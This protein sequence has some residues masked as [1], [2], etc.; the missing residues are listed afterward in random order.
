MRSRGLTESSATAHWQ[1]S[2]LLEVITSVVETI[3]R[4]LSFGTQKATPAVATCIERWVVWSGGDAARQ[5]NP[6]RTY[7]WYLAAGRKNISVSTGGLSS[8]NLAVVI[9]K[10]A[11]RA[12]GGPELVGSISSVLTALFG[13]RIAATSYRQATSLIVAFLF[14]HAVATMSAEAAEE[15]IFWILCG[16]LDEGSLYC[17]ILDT[18]KLAAETAMIWQLLGRT[19]PRFQA[20]LTLLFGG[21]EVTA[22]AGF[23]GLCVTKLLQTLFSDQLPPAAAVAVWDRLLQPP[24]AV[25]QPPVGLGY[26]RVE[27]K[28]A[29]TADGF[30]EANP[31]IVHMLY[32]GQVVQAFDSWCAANPLCTPTACTTGGQWCDGRS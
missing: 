20:R 8:D 6:S 24:P 22:E 28:A 10:D 5:A 11:P 15:K 3:D 32:P 23:S 30:L 12:A 7:A 26:F 18:V 4:T 29:V 19:L 2:D 14:N 27:S 13:G 16:V 21:D 9:E 1:M 17:S 31:E 25:L